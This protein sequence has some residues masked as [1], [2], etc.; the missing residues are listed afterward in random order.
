MLRK[1]LRQLPDVAMVV[2]VNSLAMPRSFKG[3]R[4]YL[5]SYLAWLRGRS[6]YIT[7][8][9][10]DLWI[11]F[12]GGQLW[13]IEI[14]SPGKEPEEHQEEVHEFCREMGVPTYVV[15]SIESMH[16]VIRAAAQRK[17]PDC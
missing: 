11:V 4:Y 10:H 8:G 7:S 9:L 16:A 6:G 3:K 15:D 5:R 13:L 1:G 2:R 14:K 17:G 12:R